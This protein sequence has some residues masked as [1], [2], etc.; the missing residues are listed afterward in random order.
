MAEGETKFMRNYA[1]Y[2]SSSFSF[3]FSLSLPEAEFITN[4]RWLTSNW[5]TKEKEKNATRVT[6]FNA[7]ILFARP[8]IS[9]WKKI[10]YFSQIQL[11]FAFLPCHIWGR[12]QSRLVGTP[13]NKLRLLPFFFFKYYWSSLLVSPVCRILPPPPPSYY[14]SNTTITCGGGFSFTT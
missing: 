8:S 6:I 11:T 5:R 10:N 9:T 14:P 1:S 4:T 7:F 12:W 2:Q 3:G 13:K